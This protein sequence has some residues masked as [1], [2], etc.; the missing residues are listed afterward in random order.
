MA[1]RQARR[2]PDPGF[3]RVCPGGLGTARES[4]IEGG[5]ADAPSTIFTV[6][7]GGLDKTVTI[8]ALSAPDSGMQVTDPVARAAFWKLAERLTDFDQG[9][10][11]ATDVYEAESYRAVLIESEPQAGRTPIEWPWPNLKL[12]DFKTAADGSGPTS[13]PHRV[14]TSAEVAQIGVKETE[15]GLQG[16]LL[17]GTD[18]KPYSLIVRPL[19]VDE[20]E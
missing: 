2:G 16:I 10:S 1:D 8:N 20:K 11:I 14:L 5:I 3:A 18:G 7:A 12:A 6:R 4:Y 15:G 17:A 19:L 9:G 13:F